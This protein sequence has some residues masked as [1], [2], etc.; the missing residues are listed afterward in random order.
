MSEASFT[1]R[2]RK[3]V[4]R[5]GVR[6]AEKVARVCITI[7]GAGTI[8]AVALILVFLGWVVFPLFLGAHFGND[9]AAIVA[10]NPGETKPL[11][12]ALDAHG[13]AAWALFDDGVVTAWTTADGALLERV[14]LCEPG[15]LRAASLSVSGDELVL[16]YADG[17][18]R[19]CTI[20]LDEGREGASAEGGSVQ[21]SASAE[22]NAA[23]ASVDDTRAANGGE[24]PLHATKL[25]ISPKLSIH[26]SDPIDSGTHDPIVRVDRSEASARDFLCALD[27]AGRLTFIVTERRDNL[28]TGETTSS[29]ERFALPYEAPQGA[30]PPDHVLV[31]GG[32]SSVFVAWKNGRLV[33]F[34]TRDPEHASLAEEASL[35]ENGGELTSLA[36]LIGKNTLIS[37]DSR[38]KLRGWFCTKRADA[39]TV[40]GWALVLAH[41]IA[42]VDA[43]IVALAP[44]PRS[45]VVAA[46]SRDGEVAL[47]HVTSHKLL[48]HDRVTNARERAADVRSTPT[49]R[50]ATAVEAASS[51]RTAN[52][53]AR[54][55]GS[56]P[57]AAVAFSPKEDG[58]VALDA[59]G[60][61]RWSLDLRHPEASLSALFRPVW[62][63]GY[64][65]PGHSWQSTGTG[66]SEPKLGLMPLVFGTLKAT[67]YSMLFGL[68]IALLAAVYTSEF[69]KPK[70]R[71]PLKSIT[72]M[73]ASLPSVVL[74]FLA[75]IV[76]AP[77]AR[78]FV[79]AVLTAFVTI[80]G[81]LLLGAHLW[82]LL[83][84]RTTVRLSGAPRFMLIALSLP[85]GAL[86]AFALGPLVE[87]LLF[88]GNF[89]AWLDGQ[90]GAGAIGGWA[91]LAL[92]ASIACVLF[93]SARFVDPWVRRVSAPW[94]RARCARFQ[95]FK[96]AIG[97][98]LA[99]ALAFGVAFVLGGLWLDPRGGVLDTYVQSNALVVGFVMGFAVIPIVYTL[100]EDALSSVPQHLRLA[101]LGA[102][103]TP[104]QTAVRV[105][106][107]TAMSGLFSAAMIGLGRAVGE[108]MI[109]VMASGNTPVMSWNVFNGLRTLS[110]NLATELPEAVRNST[111]YRTL[112][113]AA[114]C[115]F[116]MTFAFN[117]LAEVVRQRFRKRA[118]QL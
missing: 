67:F 51:D 3:R 2:P 65:S 109:V 26:W 94:T 7:G 27:A 58:V 93:V 28:L 71:A 108:T 114:L 38:G 52:A 45:R 107:P 60:I 1:G 97:S 48:A 30:P 40:D 53:E 89:L 77:F 79:P 105:V 82:Q 14:V 37:G 103:A 22:T 90:G 74:G 47:F 63:D 85:L 33:R 87:R 18:I 84:Q 104:W 66:D 15:T 39:H 59:R 11:C 98:A 55:S 80:P 4:T 5:R 75:A 83:P 42:R 69:L 56:R 54:A 36:F 112:F 41:E 43:P 111:H 91:V 101:S 29:V 17:S 10:R 16:G 24:A 61:T 76:I 19:A 25:A 13:A 32:G 35:V 106:I 118:Y 21:A 44:S 73:M 62:Y 102:G 99:V 23:S 12:M 110:A 72:E 92:P 100:A 64:D 95:L 46:G 115:L 78:T 88:A 31:S 116:A 50:D 70:L 34:D 57:I 9:G 86:A 8:A 81:A 96:L 113:L 68:P 6:I 20:G 49:A 117:T